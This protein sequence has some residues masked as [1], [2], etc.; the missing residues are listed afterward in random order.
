MNKNFSFGVL[1]VNDIKTNLES[2]TDSDNSLYTDENKKEKSTYSKYY[3]IIS[4][5]LGSFCMFVVLYLTQRIFNEKYVMLIG[6][7]F[8]TASNIRMCAGNILNG[9]SL[10]YSFSVCLGSNTSL[11]LAYDFMSPLNLLYLLFYNADINAVTAAVVILK[12]GLAAL[13]FQIF[14]FKCLKAKGITSIIFSLFYGMCAFSLTHGIFNN[15]WADA[16]YVLPIVCMGVYFLIQKKKPYFLIIAYAYAFI[17]NFYTGYMI[18]VFSFILF[19]MLLFTIKHGH[20]KTEIVLKYFLSVVISVLLA[21]FVWMPALFCVINY[22]GEGFDSFYGITI[23]IL[24]IICCMFWGIVNTEVSLPHI[25]CGVPCAVLLILFFVNKKIPIRFKISSGIMLAFFVLCFL[26]TPFYKFIHAVDTPVGYD[27]RFSF[28]VSFLICSLACITVNNLSGIKALW[29]PIICAGFA[30][31]LF[32]VRIVAGYSNEDLMGNKYITVIM[33]VILLLSWCVLL[34][35]VIKDKKKSYTVLMVLLVLIEIVSNG[36]Y[37]CKAYGKLEKR[38]Y[39]L[40]DYYMDEVLNENVLDGSDNE[41]Y[42]TVYGI[43]INENSGS[44]YGIN[45]IAYFGS[46]DIPGVRETLQRMGYIVSQH[47]IHET[48]TN[49]VS[50]MVLG[51]KNR[52]FGD[53]PREMINEIPSSLVK[54][55]NDYY[56]SVGYM[57]NDDLKD[58]RL[59]KRNAFENNNMIISSMTGIESVFEPVDVN[60]VR[61]FRYG[62]EIYKVEDQLALVRNDSGVATVDIRMDDYNDY[63]KYIQFEFEKPADYATTYYVHGVG[64]YMYTDGENGDLFLTFGNIVKMMKNED[65][66]YNILIRSYSDDDPVLYLNQINYYELNE[67]KLQQAYSYLDKEKFR[68]DNYKNGYVKGSIVV[69]DDKKLLF[70]SIPYIKGW[71][72]YVNGNAEEIIPVLNDTFMG[73][74]LPGK[75]EYEIELKFECPWVKQGIAMSLSGMLILGIMYFIDFRIAKTNRSKK[76]N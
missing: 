4:F 61:I 17:V 49:P 67:D 7:G 63:P 43:D 31:F 52:F 23:N 69:E 38:G 28:I 62:M 3:P 8:K 5:I 1:V 72:A 39:D 68:V 35:S 75:G 44:F 54:E 15:F 34:V 18:G 74:E 10:Y 48:G 33:N 25:Y 24:D 57:V 59:D 50:E 66:E 37:K 21:S 71:K 47:R 53:D 20:K 22:S 9:E 36:F 40:W 76:E 55:E 64:N 30:A 29:I 58:L 60:H 65:G 56:I 6:D 13:A 32:A 19:F 14:S 46:N 70:V 26:T 42:R 11:L 45:R 12:V 73:L 41:L 16:V 51:V 27:F 2:V